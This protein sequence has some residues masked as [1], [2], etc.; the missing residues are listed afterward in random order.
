MERKIIYEQ[1]TLHRAITMC[2]GDEMKN[3]FMLDNYGDVVHIK[4]TSQGFYSW[5]H[6]DF[7]KK[8]EVTVDE[9]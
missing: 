5:V 8:K 3:L 1:I 6:Q 4:G 9:R 2:L 7:Y